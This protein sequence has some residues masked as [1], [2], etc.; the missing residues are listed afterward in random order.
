MGLVPKRV[1]A[2]YTAQA[3]E[4]V[5]CGAAGLTITLPTAQ[6]NGTLIG[7]HGYGCTV[8]GGGNTVFRN[9]VQAASTKT[10]DDSTLVLIWSADGYWRVVSDTHPPL[11][12]TNLA[13]YFNATNWT[14]YNPSGPWGPCQFTKNSHGYVRMR[15][16]AK[17]VAAYTNGAAT[18]VIATLPVGYR[19]TIN[20]MFS[21]LQA[22]STSQ[23]F[24]NRLDAYPSGQL[25]IIG[26]GI[27][28]GNNGVATYVTLDSIAFYAG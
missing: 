8:A 1:T 24:L 2:N 15:G 20:Q 7:I 5:I 14:D 28:V 17:S 4:F 26:G 23:Y 19:P 6:P 25:Q 12:W 10:V 18:A 22:D 13:P 3:Q 11:T 27:G 21:A 9:S 16:L